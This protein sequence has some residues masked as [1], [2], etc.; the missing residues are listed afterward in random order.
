MGLIN[1]A[2]DQNPPHSDQHSSRFPIE[3]SY[4]LP[5]RDAPLQ[6]DFL[7]QATHVGTTIVSRAAIQAPS[8]SRTKGKPESANTPV[9]NVFVSC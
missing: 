6:Q 3:R 7:D 2:I 5:G 8:S 1:N 9:C 4:P